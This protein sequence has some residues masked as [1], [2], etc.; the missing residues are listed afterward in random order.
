MSK[1]LVASEEQ[2]RTEKERREQTRK[3]ISLEF[4]RRRLRFFKIER[5]EIAAQLEYIDM[6]IK[7]YEDKIKELENG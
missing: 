7:K 5:R 2:I 1:K 4:S 6:E 3:E